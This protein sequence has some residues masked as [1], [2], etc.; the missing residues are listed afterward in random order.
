[1]SKI[2]AKGA[3]I[4]IAATDLSKYVDTY[5]IEWGVQTDEVTGFT[6]GW[7]NY[8]PGMPVVGFT[9]NF[10]WDKTAAT[11]TFAKLIALMAT[12]GT[13]SIV[14]EATGPTFSGTFFPD[15][16]KVDGKANSGAIGIS[17]VK[18]LASGSTI[19]TFA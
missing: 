19:A 11:G 7:K 10:Y 3:V 12:P 13:C 14:P 6:D 16:I 9:L 18:F 15:G 4:T 17:S 2:S 8:I 5:E 1:M